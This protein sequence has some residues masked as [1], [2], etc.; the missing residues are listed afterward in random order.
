MSITIGF[1][2]S[3]VVTGYGVVDGERLTDYGEIKVIK[4]DL[5][6]RLGFL[7]KEVERLV[8]AFKPDLGAVEKPPSFSYSRSTHKWSGKGLNAEDIIK[9]SNAGAVITAVLGRTG[10]YVDEFDAHRW[11]ICAGKNLGKEEMV[12]LARSMYPELRGKLLSDHAAEAICM[13]R[14]ARK[15]NPNWR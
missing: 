6:F 8:E 5:C 9:C 4:G 12:G 3:I 14:F 1:D 10:L 7:M 2:P 15:P 13:A 11:K